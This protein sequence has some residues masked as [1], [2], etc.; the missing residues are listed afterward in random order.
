[1]SGGAGGTTSYFGTPNIRRVAITSL[2]PRSSSE[3]KIPKNDDDFTKY[4]DPSLTD[5]RDEPLQRA[6]ATV[7][8][9]A[10]EGAE[11]VLLPETFACGDMDMHE[12][13]GYADKQV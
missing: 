3:P 9:A 11:L 4:D 12:M 1:M 2:S 6:L 8:A 7:D 13:K 5:C 10:A